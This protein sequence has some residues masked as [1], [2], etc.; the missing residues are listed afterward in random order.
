MSFF[1]FF[2][3]LYNQFLSLFPPSLQWL[4]TLGVVIGLVVGFIGLI[5]HNA[6]FLIVLVLFLPI[7]IPV[8]RQF[9][10]DIYN[11]FLYLLGIIHLTA[12]KAL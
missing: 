9:F 10:N 4:I 3:S 2:T 1:D 11:F 8:L 12:P 7:V 6:I 5:R